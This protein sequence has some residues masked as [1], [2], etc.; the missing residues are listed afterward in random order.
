VTAVVSELFHQHV[1]KDFR[2]I[3]AWVTQLGLT[4]MNH[5]RSSEAIYLEC[6]VDVMLSQ[7]L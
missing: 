3:V 2:L 5:G 1:L 7:A 6:R 4:N